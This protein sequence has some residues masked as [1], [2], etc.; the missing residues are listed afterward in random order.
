M[1]R[2][3]IDKKAILNVVIEVGTV[4]LFLAV[5]VGFVLYVFQL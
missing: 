1:S 3:D 5:A 2:P 4:L